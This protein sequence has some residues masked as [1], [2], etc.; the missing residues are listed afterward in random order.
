MKREEL[1]EAILSN[2]MQLQRAGATRLPML[3]EQQPVS[4]AQMEVLLVVKHQQP[5][6]VKAIAAQLHLTPG[7][8]TQLVEGLVQNGYLERQEGDRDRRISN[9]SLA[10]DGKQKLANLWL[11][12]KK[13]LAK[14]MQ[15]LDT[16]E[17]TTMLRI[18]E[19]M[20]TQFELEIS[21]LQ[22]KEAV[23]DAKKVH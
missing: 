16:T 8:I 11:Q 12:R 10:K 22:Q 17:L 7:A 3:L 9:I 1:L 14:I 15:T 4:R 6:S 18:Q 21:K 2:M 20:L 5:I 13:V 23:D 19:K